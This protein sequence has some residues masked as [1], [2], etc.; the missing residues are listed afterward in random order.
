[1]G[2]ILGYLLSTYKFQ[3]VTPH[4]SLTIEN[5]TEGLK[6]LSSLITLD[7]PESRLDI[8]VGQEAI[9]FQPFEVAS[10]PYE[11][12]SISKSDYPK[13]FEQGVANFS[14]ITVQLFQKDNNYFVLLSN[15]Q[16]SHG[17][18]VPEYKLTVDPFTKEVKE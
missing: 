1:M 5:K 3:F 18:F 12:F 4:N 10:S 7:I 16:P 8:L 6:P 14:F 17:G 9:I 13:M 2:L 11:S 15:N